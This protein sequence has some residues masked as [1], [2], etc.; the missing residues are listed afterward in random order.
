MIEARQ[1][2]GFADDEQRDGLAVLVSVTK[3]HNKA[4]ELQRT[5]MDLARLRGMD[6]RTASELLGKVYAGNTG[7]LSRYG[8]VLKE[9]TTATQAIAEIQKRAAGQAEAYGDTTAGAMEAASIAIDNLKED[10]GKLLLPIIKDGAQFLTKTAIPAFRDAAKGIELIAEGARNAIPGLSTFFDLI[11]EGAGKD[12]GIDLLAFLPGV[13]AGA[14][15]MKDEAT[16]AMV[17]LREQTADDMGR[18]QQIV[19][20]TRLWDEARDIWA[21]GSERLWS[22]L[23]R[24]FGLSFEETIAIAE[25]AGNRLPHV[26]AEGILDAREAPMDAIDA[27]KALMKNSMSETAETSRLLGQLAS[28]ELA[29]GLIDKDPA[30]RNAASGA[31]NSIINRLADL[32]VTPGTLTEKGMD[33]LVAA[34]DSADPIIARAAKQI[35]DTVVNTLPTEKEMSAGGLAAG[36]AWAA[37]LSASKAA[38]VR[39]A[40]AMAEDVAELLIGR[41]P[42]PAGPLKDLDIGGYRAGVAWA[43]GLA[44]GLGTAKAKAATELGALS[45]GFRSWEDAFTQGGLGAAQDFLNVEAARPTG[46]HYE[47]PEPGVWNWIP[48]PPA[49]AGGADVGS[50]GTGGGSG[51]SAGGGSGSASGFGSFDY[52]ALS[53][54]VGDGILNAVPMIAMPPIRIEVQ[55]VLDRA[56]ADRVVAQLDEA[57]RRL[58][59]SSGYVT[60]ATT[61]TAD[62]P[63][64]HS[65]VP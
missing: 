8:I 61:A 60:G 5:A 65:L 59:R 64:T 15:K 23:N 12:S 53:A 58:W 31:R 10:F 39:A 17:E 38:A 33:A 32:E 20:N 51:F 18:I 42:P 52:M 49:G 35:H 46:G 34:M 21:Q 55:G 62:V 11:D 63:H 47:N 6:L 50:S 14:T 9:G 16:A 45:A 57:M 13:A 44:L 2:L 25:E 41:S 24:T 28:E 36:Q 56:V 48:D 7:I 54:A 27:L 40:T 22:D 43:D 26:F 1:S 19:I 3:D 4:L 29:K 30:V 37:G